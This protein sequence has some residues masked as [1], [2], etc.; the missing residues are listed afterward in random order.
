MILII[1]GDNLPD[2]TV[3]KLGQLDESDSVMIYYAS[4]N[5]FFTKES[6][7]VPLI[8]NTRCNVTFKCIPAG[9]CAVD[10]AVAIDLGTILHTMPGKVLIL[11]SKDK[12]FKIIQ[13]L[14]KESSPEWYIAQAADVDEAVEGYKIL[15]TAS[16]V[17][18]H[19]WLIHMFG[20]RNG[21]EVYARIEEL[22]AD[23]YAGMKIITK[24]VCRIEDLFGRIKKETSAP[25]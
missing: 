17:D 3:K 15:E 11:I 21:N 8:D 12:H 13:S 14:I 16:L 6:N 22:Y 1:D 23:K 10:L 4:D 25:P 2:I 24:L 20:G 18:F 9:N 5:G 7:R 19:N